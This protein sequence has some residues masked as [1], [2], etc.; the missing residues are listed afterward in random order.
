MRTDNKFYSRHSLPNKK[1]E[2]QEPRLLSSNSVEIDENRISCFIGQ[3]RAFAV[4]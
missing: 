2:Q 3:R 4:S 1:K